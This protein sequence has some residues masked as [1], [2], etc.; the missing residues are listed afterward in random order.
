VKFDTFPFHQYGLAHGVV[1]TISADSFTT[2]DEQRN[3]TGMVPMPTNSSEPFYRA[4]IT[5]DR[6][7]L[8]DTPEGFRITP[9]MP[10]TADV[11]VGKRTVLSYLLG[12]VLPVAYEGMREP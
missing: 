4:R 5:I 10:V 6:V 8:H 9:G 3:P 7:A 2:Q 1:R 11:K 12:K